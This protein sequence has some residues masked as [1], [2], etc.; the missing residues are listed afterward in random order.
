[1][2][3]AVLADAADR[4][5]IA[6]ELAATLF[7]EAGAG[8]GKTR[9][10]VD[11]LVGL[12]RSGV[13]VAGLAA[14]TFT[15]AAAAELR[16]RVRERLV[17]L[18]ADQPDDPVLRRALGD[19]DD[20]ALTTIHGFCQKILLEDPLRAGLPLRVRVLDDIE[21]ELE[22]EARFSAF[23]D[24]LFDEPAAQSLV[25]AALALGLSP[26]DL[27]GLARALEDRW[28]LDVADAAA[29]GDLRTAAEGAHRAVAEALAPLPH[30]LAHCTDEDD[31]LHR[32][33][34]GLVRASA[35]FAT[36]EGWLDRLR[37]V[38]LLD[39]PRVG[40]AGKKTAW[41]GCDVEEVRAAVATV[42][43]VREEALGQLHDAVLRALLG[44]LAGAARLGAAA[45]RRRG[46]LVFHDLLVFCRDLLRTDPAVR[47]ALRARIGHVLVDEFQDT[48]ELQLEILM[49]IGAPGD[50]AP[51]DPGRLFFVGDP[52]QAI[53]RFRGAD[54]GL[55]ERARAAL[56]ERAQ[57]R[58]VA[59]FRSVPG[60][61]DFVNALFARLLADGA[62]APAPLVAARPGLGAT[63]VHL[64]GAPLADVNAAER[65]REE[66][67]LVADALARV[68]A[69]GWTVAEGEHV[70][71]ARYG[72]IAVLV[73]RRT[74]LGELEAALEAAGVPYRLAA[75]ALVYA[76]PEVHDLLACLRA[77]ERPGEERAVLGALRS[78]AF[79][80]DDGALLA[81]RRA[82][83]Q[84]RIGAAPPPGCAAG[85]VVAALADLGRLRALRHGRSVADLVAAVIADRQLYAGAAALARRE[86]AWR[87]LASVL[88][89]ASAYA[90]AGGAHLGGFLA[91]AERQEKRRSAEQIPAEPDDDAVQ[92]LTVHA[93]KGLEFPVVVVAELGS[94]P[95]GPAGPT[96]LPGADGRLEVRVRA[97]CAT[98]GFVA[99]A[100]EDRLA[101]SEEQ[102]R[103]AYVATTRARDHLLV[104]VVHQPAA[105]PANMTLAEQVQRACQEF[106]G[107][108]HLPPRG[109]ASRGERPVAPAPSDA[110]AAAAYGATLAERRALLAA[111][112]SR[113]VVAPSA[114]GVVGAPS[115][116]SA[117]AAT[118]LGRAVHAVLERVDLTTGQGLDELA[119]AAAAAAGCAGEGERVAQLA[120]AALA[121]P[122][123]RAASTADQ[124]WRELPLLASVG[125]VLVDGAVD[126]CYRRGDEIV[127]V[128]YKTD[129]LAASESAAA[130]AERH[131]LQVGC[132]ALALGAVLGRRV[133][134]C[135]LVFLAADGRALEHE[136]AALDELAAAAGAAL[137]T[138][139]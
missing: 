24:A 25:S 17:R 129:V 55:Y 11:R 56:E 133:D 57:A 1:M 26:E 51:L 132:Y 99:A 39:V 83:G 131:R 34:G 118:A 47:A 13:P 139:R 126:L 65:R 84:W 48:D 88:A 123:V 96:I 124:V 72:D 91:W 37:A 114:L 6:T 68:V 15:E 40:R 136:F 112:P 77:I 127:I 29:D 36:R 46:E 79:G 102:L 9:A 62:V 106:G 4:E 130:A 63:A 32:A 10:L 138:S 21:A 90:E 41:P 81:Y 104:S 74:G 28:H 20:A 14:I 12:I 110:A 22:F 75:S 109:A 115:P 93:A 101:G 66:A 52:K 31:R 82:G 137:A 42:R 18:S 103:L 71:P 86:D 113:P 3:E 73:T 78:T 108:E 94:T 121:A 116:E 61:L 135:V 95:R 70:R 76:S 44:R 92:V 100:E 58:L 120:A 111:A 30:L 87:R 128:D 64:L 27:R 117:G 107:W 97:G 43:E 54:V 45:R 89:D 85:P 23:L 8:T 105:G 35:R 67:Q 49:L 119:V 50:G 98:R 33:L 5:R 125:D 53:Y 7:V 16:A 134:R 69:E 60:V 122:S 80:C 2:S 38:A 59:N 19:L